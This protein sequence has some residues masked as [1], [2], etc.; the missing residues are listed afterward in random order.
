MARVDVWTSVALFPNPTSRKRDSRW[1]ANS[2]RE[3]WTRAAGVGKV[4]ACM[5]E[6]TK[7]SSATHWLS[8]GMGPRF[9]QRMLGH[10]DARLTERYSK[11]MD[12][13]LVEQF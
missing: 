5:Y 13:A 1:I 8:A 7:H 9:V 2:L 4:E 12:S 11:V 6:G 3:E 10:R